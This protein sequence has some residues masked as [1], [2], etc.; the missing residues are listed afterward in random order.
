MQCSPSSIVWYLQDSVFMQ[1]K[2]EARIKIS[3]KEANTSAENSCYRDLLA[4]LVKDSLTDD[5]YPASLAELHYSLKSRP[6]G[7][8]LS[9]S[10]FNDKL[11]ALAETVLKRLLDFES[12]LKSLQFEAQREILIRSIKNAN[13]NSGNQVTQERRNVLA[14]RFWMED[15]KLVAT[16]ALTLENMKLCL[17]RFFRECV[18]IEA[19]V[20]GNITQDDARALSAIFEGILY[21]SCYQQV[22][23]VKVL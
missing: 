2:A 19:L 5:V 13:L 7:F 4:L 15:Q 10:G 9:F 11:L 22:C 3:F 14:D 12:H 1:P 23:I 17:S 18:R 6:F 16:K 20:H 21:C 8:Y